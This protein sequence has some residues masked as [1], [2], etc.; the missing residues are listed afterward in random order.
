MFSK[1]QYKVLIQQ[2]MEKHNVSYIKALYDM[3]LETAEKM[4]AKIHIYEYMEKHGVSYTT[5]VQLMATEEI[6]QYNLSIC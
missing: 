1:T 3:D 6:S 4:F 5:A 2:Y